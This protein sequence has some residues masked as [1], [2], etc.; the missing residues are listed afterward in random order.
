MEFPSFPLFFSRKVFS[1]YHSNLGQAPVPKVHEVSSWD[2]SAGF[3]GKNAIKDG[4]T[5]GL[6]QNEQADFLGAS[7]SNIWLTSKI[8]SKDAENQCEARP[9][10]WALCGEVAKQSWIHLKLMNGGAGCP[11]PQ[12]PENKELTHLFLRREKIK[13][14]FSYDRFPNCLNTQYH[15]TS[16]FLEFQ[17][18]VPTGGA[19]NRDSGPGNK[20]HS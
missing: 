20:P 19:R 3:P 12:R 5:P 7:G 9:G 13:L 11:R 10:V 8:H 1:T 18:Q 6:I 4:W 16:S 17:N 15:N 2:V 14:F